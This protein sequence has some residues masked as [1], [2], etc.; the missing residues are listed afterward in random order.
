M[1][2]ST[3]YYNTFIEVAEDSKVITGIE[4]PVRGEKKSIANYEFELIANHPYQY[5]SDDVIFQVYALRNQLPSSNLEKERE[6]FFAKGRPCFRASPLT[7]TYGWGV[8]S[9]KLG[10]IAIYSVDSNKYAE[11]VADDNVVKKKAIRSRKP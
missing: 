10:K 7:K 4:P 5:T 3:N 11:L 9:N 6:L 2:N 8:H 1:Q